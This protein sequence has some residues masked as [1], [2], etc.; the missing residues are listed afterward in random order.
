MS[1]LDHYAATLAKL[2]MNSVITLSTQVE[3]ELVGRVYT[4]LGKWT[5]L[6]ALGVQRNLH[7]AGCTTRA[8]MGGMLLTPLGVE[9]AKAIAVDVQQALRMCRQPAA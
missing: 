9:L 1:T 7:K 8:D 2:T 5:T 3:G 4:G 6:A